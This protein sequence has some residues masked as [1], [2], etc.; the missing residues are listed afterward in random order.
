[1]GWHCGREPA[2]KSPSISAEPRESRNFQT[3]TCSSKARTQ[4]ASARDSSGRV[5]E[6]GRM[7][8]QAVACIYC[9]MRADVGTTID[10]SADFCSPLRSV[11]RMGRNDVLRE[12]FTMGLP[13]EYHAIF[14]LF[15][16]SLHEG[17]V[18]LLRNLHAAVS[19]QERHLVNRDS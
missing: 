14:Q 2:T 5:G 4:G 11:N 8:G 13:T 6:N 10:A 18:V 17:R 15:L 19:Q 16:P 9:L 3:R 7:A 12:P 1:M